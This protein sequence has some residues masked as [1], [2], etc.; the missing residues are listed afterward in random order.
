MH[1]SLFA[2]YSVLV[3]RHCIYNYVEVRLAN[4]HGIEGVAAGLLVITFTFLA[5]NI[6][7][8]CLLLIFNDCNIKLPCV[9]LLKEILLITFYLIFIIILHSRHNY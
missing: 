4:G 1:Q 3:M 6:N 8:P 9:M 5:C 2:V 7:S